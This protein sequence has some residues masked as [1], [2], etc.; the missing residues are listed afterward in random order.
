MGINRD[1]GINLD[2]CNLDRDWSIEMLT[3]PEVSEGTKICFASQ[4][5]TVQGR[6]SFIRWLNLWKLG[7]RY[8]ICW[9]NI[10]SFILRKP[11]W[12]EKKKKIPPQILKHKH[13]TNQNLSKINEP[14]LF[15]FC[16]RSIY[17]VWSKTLNFFYLNK[18][19]FIVKSYPS[20]L[21]DSPF[22]IQI[23]TL[24]PSPW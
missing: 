11:F 21:K 22:F 3:V 24:L 16:W 18:E 6:S 9:I 4:L 12:E 8:M 23:E 17:R 2:R 15:P 13:Y 7:R 14:V 5:C 19:S 10:H 1:I 20:S